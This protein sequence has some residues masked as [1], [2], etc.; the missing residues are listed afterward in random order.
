MLLMSAT[1][2]AKP[3]SPKPL[4]LIP[5]GFV[6]GILAALAAVLAREGADR[7]V[8]SHEDVVRDLRLPML[9]SL[10]PMRAGVVARGLVK[11]LQAVGLW[12]RLGRWSRP[13]QPRSAT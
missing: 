6:V 9:G 8:R 1:Q 13:L 4:L 11:P 12:T 3:S 7:R 10:R 2:P 5:I